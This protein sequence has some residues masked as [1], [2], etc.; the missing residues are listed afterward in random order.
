MTTTTMKAGTDG[1]MQPLVQ[2]A[3]ALARPVV[4]FLS[5]SKVDGLVELITGITQRFV[6]ELLAAEDADD[7][8]DIVTNIA[9]DPEFGAWMHKLT[10]LKF[11]QFGNG[12]REEA[13]GVARTVL[14]SAEPSDQHAIGRL[15]WAFNEITPLMRPDARLPPARLVA[16][17]LACPAEFAHA[18]ASPDRIA[19]EMLG[20]AVGDHAPDWLVQALVDML[21]ADLR[22]MLS[23]AGACAQPEA[24][25]ILDR[26]GLEPAPLQTW[27]DEYVHFGREIDRQVEAARAGQP[28]PFA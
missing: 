8:R 22:T 13:M 4:R 2:F 16:R 24:R 14:Y 10:T 20:L 11:D 12:G 7:L 6:P 27:V 17:D 1:W 9:L 3:E 18:L 15:L 19:V 5:K 21:D 28:R 26:F 23:L 25:H